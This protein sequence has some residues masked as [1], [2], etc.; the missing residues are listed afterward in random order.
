MLGVLSESVLLVS[1]LMFDFGEHRGLLG[2][3]VEGAADVLEGGA[4]LGGLEEGEVVG[5][6]FA[7]HT[8]NNLT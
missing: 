8:V 6:G 3:A 5:C 1:Y 7:I 2:L 4:G